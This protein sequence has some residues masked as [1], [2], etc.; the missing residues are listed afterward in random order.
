M[1]SAPTQ[2]PYIVGL[3]GGIGSGKTTVSEMFAA[4]GVEVVD[5]DAIS[6]E[7]VTPDS[8]ALRSIIERFGPELLN[9]DGSLHRQRLRN[10]IFHDS[11]AKAWLEGLLHPL[12]RSAIRTRIAA[13]KSPWLLLSAPLLLESQAYDFVDRVLVVDASEH[14][15]VNRVTQR[16]GSSTGDVIRIMAN[17]LPRAARLQLAD[18]IIENSGSLDALKKQ[19]ITLAAKY[20]EAARVRH[21]TS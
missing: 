8:A 15:Q 9:A 5:A 1:T 14:T 10:L 16:D 2:T 18:D 12:I 4:L 11:A 17:Q 13:S 6:R 21:Q 20:E 7:I 19:V 3:T